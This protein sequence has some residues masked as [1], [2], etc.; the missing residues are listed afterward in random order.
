MAEKDGKETCRGAGWLFTRTKTTDISYKYSNISK[1][2]KEE[3][4]GANDTILL[5]S[6]AT[7][8]LCP[9]PYGKEYSTVIFTKS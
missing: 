1:Y 7:S 4:K 9:V 5:V 6:V 2:V 3:F 8:N